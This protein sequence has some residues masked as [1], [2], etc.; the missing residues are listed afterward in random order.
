MV[1]ME[2]TITVPSRTSVFI[3][4]RLIGSSAPAQDVRLEVSR[5]EHHQLFRTTARHSSH[6]TASVTGV[7]PTGN[8]DDKNT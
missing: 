4:Q 5:V 2:L 7:Q 8:T 3:R 1:E 6:G